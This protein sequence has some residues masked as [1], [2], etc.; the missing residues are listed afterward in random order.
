MNGKRQS[1]V[2]VLLLGACLA[3]R[4]DVRAT[5]STVVISQ[6]YGGGGNSGATYTNDFVE[7]F[8]RGAVPVDLSGW[9]V[10]YASAT[11]T[12]WQRTDL[13]GTVQPGQY[14]LVQESAGTAG[15]VSLPTPDAIGTIAMSATAGKVAL[16]SSATSLSGACPTGAWVDL[17]GY[18]AAN[19]SEAAAA[20]AL[21]NATADLRKATGCTDTDSNASDFAP[22]APSPR[23]GASPLSPCSSGDAAP[24]VQSTSPASGAV[25]VAP[26]SSISVTFTE[27]VFVAGGWYSIDCTVTGNHL[28]SESGGPQTFTLDPSAD[29]S[30]GETCTVT[31]FA[32]AVTDQDGN[33]DHP[34]ADDSFSFTTVAPV[35]P[36]ARIH[37][38]QG[39]A[40][41]SPLN[42]S[43]VSNVP[44]IVT[45]KASNGFY[46]Q[47]PNPDGDDATS[48]GIFVFTSSAPSAVTVG[49]DVRVSGGVSEFRPGGAAA[50]LTTTEIVT[51]TV[52]VISSGNALPPP[53]VIGNGGRVPPNT[54]IEDDATGDVETSGVF[55]PASDGIDFYE[56]LEGMRVQINDAVA[57]GPTN[58]FGE[59]P[60]VGDNGVNASLRTGRGGVIIQPTDF[61]PERIIVDDGL[62]AM[63]SVNV[64]DRFPGPLVGVMSY[65]FGNFMV[66]VTSSPSAVSGG[67]AQQVLAPAGAGQLAVATFNVEN[68][69]P[70]DPPAKFSQLAHLIT[71][72]LGSPD[73]LALE[74]MQDDN[75][76]VDDAVVSASTTFATLISAIQA[77]GGPTYTYREIDPVNDQD[78][79]EPGGNIRQGFLFRTD[80]GL[81]FIDRPGGDSV[82]P[83]TVVS[84]ELGPE[85][86]ASPGRIQPGDPAFTSSRKPLAGEFTFSG[87][88]LFVIANHFNAKLGDDPLFGRFQP[89]TRSSEPQR[90]QQ[91]EIV[92]TFVRGILD[93]DADARVVVLGDFNDFE[94]SDTITILKSA[95]LHDLIE[96]LP[97]SERYSYVFEGN[98]QTLDH[99]LVS[100]ALFAQPFTHDVVH[101]NSEFTVQASDHDPQVARIL[102]ATP[103]PTATSTPTA[104]VTPTVTATP[105]PTSTPSPTAT[106]TPTSTSTATPTSTSTP[107]ATSTS[108][109]T[110]TPTSTPR[111]TATWTPTATR[112][113][114]P[115]ATPR[116]PSLSIADAAIT[117]GNS[118]AR[119]MALA[120][121]LSSASSRP[122]VVLYA[123]A[124][125]T[126]S[127]PSDY[128]PAAGVL[129][130]A[131]GQ[132]GKTIHV[133]VKGDRRR[134]ANE[135]IRVRLLLPLNA[136]LARAEAIGTILNDD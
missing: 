29:F 47:D 49:D 31:V 1:F 82:T 128:A 34:V 88:H 42:G 131:P 54:V 45:A 57:V 8:N 93:L 7:L 43:A 41:I 98:S 18:G 50:N 73:L 87:R 117:E 33:P 32:A 121:T 12:T 40:H 134:E 95:P 135:T 124:D 114:T 62:T 108:T 109:V 77:A 133:A 107:T 99:V 25:N 76:A 6:V 66:E 101:V 59:T 28:A 67:L 23:N 27:P 5:S 74:E 52:V 119:D 90:H 96:T 75:G 35:A 39:A 63:P 113:V 70:S 100:D 118:G 20:A 4:A 65:D 3:L 51:P 125:G 9:S 2:A 72:N 91:A 132:R 55:D 56:S 84:G 111:P 102:F 60:V 24:A 11:G 115:T 68:L 30:Q 94:F 36:S 126:A 83:T 97:P 13:A 21:T 112:T 85:L 136:T 22:G 44:G 110:P 106:G 80:R 46:L 104:T 61:N 71:D 130:F 116:L 89:P 15:T 37:D 48:E 123:T 64:A 17:V 26:A 14:Y 120:V 92:R 58:A 19:C 105:T 86:S 16:V 129:V 103:T 81:A 53:I 78:G 122:V 38:I 127:A 79:G 10:Q 69:D